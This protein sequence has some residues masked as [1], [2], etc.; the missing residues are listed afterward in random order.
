MGE[1]TDLHQFIWL[2]KDRPKLVNSGDAYLI[3]PSNIPLDV[4]SAYSKV[5]HVIEK[6]VIINQIRSGVVVRYFYVYRMR[7]Y[8]G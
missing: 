8:R 3:V 7:G 1:L 2:N 4:L 5:F 6:P